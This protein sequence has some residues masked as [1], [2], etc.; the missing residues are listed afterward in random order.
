MD[1]AAERLREN[2]DSRDRNRILVRAACRVGNL[3]RARR[4]I[5]GWLERDGRDPEALAFLSDVLGRQGKREQAI[6]VLSG[7]ADLRPDDAA[8]HRRLALAFER[9]G[10]AERACSHR[11]ALAEMMMDNASAVGAAVGCQQK[12]GRKGS[13]E[14]LLAAVIDEET[15]ESARQAAAGRAVGDGEE[16]AREELRLSASWVRE[17]DLDL[18]IITPGGVRLSWLGGRADVVASRVAEGGREQL[19]VR[20]V[21]DGSYVIEISRVGTGAGA[22]VQGRVTVRLLEDSRDLPFKLTGERA[23]L[24]RLTV[25]EKSR[26]APR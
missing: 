8:L 22:P 7:I 1:A 18:S 9:A 10:M 4:L 25:V 2:P 12:L 14:R 26:L 6:R 11:V 21:T 16:E 13:A 15:R 19:G 17:A 24:G 3:E 20:D 23:V 5:D